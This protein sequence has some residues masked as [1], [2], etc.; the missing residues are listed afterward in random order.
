MFTAIPCKMALR[1]CSNIVS[2]VG[3][4]TCTNYSNNTSIFILGNWRHY[5]LTSMNALF[6]QSSSS[7][8]LKS[9]QYQ[10][11]SSSGTRHKDLSNDITKVKDSEIQ[12]ATFSQKTKENV[13]TASYGMVIVVGIG[14]TSVVL[15]TVLKELFSR[16]SPTALFQ[17][18]SDKC[19]EHPNVQDLLGEPIKAFGEE[20]RR[21]RRRHVT[22]LDYVDDQGRKGIRV[23]FY[24]QGLRKRGTAQIDAREDAN[25]KLQTRYIVV[26][27]DDL[28]RTSVVV[29]DNR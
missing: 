16:D 10:C 5:S 28:L 11:F 17:M 4:K 19:T 20:T 3:F 8:P 9:S 15:Y 27:A 25:G 13:K 6:Q 26:T 18:A 21:G 7:I 14:V 23:Q 1:R 29:E 22:H 24:L 2:K 12:T